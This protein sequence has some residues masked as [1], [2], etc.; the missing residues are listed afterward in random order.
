[1][2]SLSRTLCNVEHCRVRR[3]GVRAYASIGTDRVGDVEAFLYGPILSS[4]CCERAPSGLMTVW[5]R[6][7]RRVGPRADTASGKTLGGF[8]VVHS[9]RPRAEFLISNVDAERRNGGFP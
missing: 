6:R 7:A 5:A 2:H 8:A 4:N 9:L 1:M 3:D